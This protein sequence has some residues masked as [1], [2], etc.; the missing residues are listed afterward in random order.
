M[1]RKQ[2]VEVQCDRCKRIEYQDGKNPTKNET[3][4]QDFEGTFMGQQVKF[5]DLCNPCKKTVG[6]YWDKITTELEGKSPE[7]GAKGKGQSETNPSPPILG[8]TGSAPV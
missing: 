2:V 4:A 3:H 8:S 1:A 5:T 6:G 7:R